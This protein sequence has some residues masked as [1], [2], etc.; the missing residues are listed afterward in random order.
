[1]SVR[2]SSS[3]GLI[4]IVGWLIMELL[5]SPTEDSDGWDWSLKVQWSHLQA[6][7][8]AN[9]AERSRSCHVIAC[10]LW[11]ACFNVSAM[12]LVKFLSLQLRFL[13]DS[14]LS[15]TNKSCALRNFDG[16]CST[17]PRRPCLKAG[18]YALSWACDEAFDCTNLGSYA[19]L[20]HW[21]RWMITQRGFLRRWNAV[22]VKADRRASI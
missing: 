4:Y 2:P 18:S 21:N 13:T 10:H 14:Y 20:L 5:F 15:C 17:K 9:I 6:S 3:I 12:I 19:G 16:K 7:S 11:Q 22:F 8:D 1:M